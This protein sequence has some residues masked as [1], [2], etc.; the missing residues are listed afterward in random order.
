MLSLLVSHTM[1][2]HLHK[3][4]INLLTSHMIQ[5]SSGYDSRFPRKRPWFESQLAILFYILL[6]YFSFCFCCFYFD[7]FF[8]LTTSTIR[9][10]LHID[11]PPISAFRYKITKAVD[12]LYCVQKFSIFLCSHSTCLH[13]R[14]IFDH[15]N[16]VFMQQHITCFYAATRVYRVYITFLIICFSKCLKLLHL[17]HIKANC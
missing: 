15:T 2:R 7:R 13:I 16:E 6:L 3:Y 14:A 8:S 1:Y 12:I 11:N 10:F 9:Q 17:S 5:Y 4:F